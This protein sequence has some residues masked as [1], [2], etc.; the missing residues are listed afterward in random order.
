M[1]L[2]TFVLEADSEPRIGAVTTAGIVDFRQ[3]APA[4]PQTLSGLLA[5]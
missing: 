5:F 2:A 4:L 1:R 3:A